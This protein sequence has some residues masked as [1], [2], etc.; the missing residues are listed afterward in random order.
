MSSLFIN[1]LPFDCINFNIANMSEVFPDP[2]SP[3]IP[4][5]SPSFKVKL[6]FVIAFT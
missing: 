3:T 4:K 1:I 2:D 5:L 6:I